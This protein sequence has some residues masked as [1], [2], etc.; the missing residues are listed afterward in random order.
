MS[1]LADVALPLRDW[2][3]VLFPGQ[4]RDVV[5]GYLEPGRFDRSRLHPFADINRSAVADA[6]YQDLR[7]KSLLDI[8]IWSQLDISSMA[9]RVIAYIDVKK[10]YVQFLCLSY[11]HVSSPV[12]RSSRASRSLWQRTECISLK[13]IADLNAL[14]FVDAVKTDDAF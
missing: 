12:H 8:N 9:Q 14:N 6:I 3:Q 1:S 2:F 4:R 11:S 10:E 13:S 7:T 5:A